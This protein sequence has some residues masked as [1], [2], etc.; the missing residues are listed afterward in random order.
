MCSVGRSV[1][2]PWPFDLLALACCVARYGR[3]FFSGGGSEQTP[4]ILAVWLRLL[5]PIAQSSW[6]F[7][8]RSPRL[9][10]TIFKCSNFYIEVYL[11]VY[12]SSTTRNMWCADMCGSPSFVHIFGLPAIRLNW[13]LSVGCWVNA[14][15]NWTMPAAGV[16]ELSTVCPI[17]TLLGFV[18]LEGDSTIF[19]QTSAV[20][21]YIWRL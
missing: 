14:R 8:S 5:R 2:E 1:C 6:I 10:R 17:W 4:S 12:Y 7:C 15:A 18:H 21:L 9:F 20:V 16:D 11:Q 13:L 3:V 19:L